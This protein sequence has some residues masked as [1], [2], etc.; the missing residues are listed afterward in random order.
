MYLGSVGKKLDYSFK[1][2]IIDEIN[3]F[4]AK[5]YLVLY[6][7]TVVFKLS[8]HLNLKIL[9]LWDGDNFKNIWVQPFRKPVWENIP[10]IFPTDHLPLAVTIGREN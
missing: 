6:D 7:S 1:D 4:S 5:L 2:E 9:L 3:I 8:K 10:G